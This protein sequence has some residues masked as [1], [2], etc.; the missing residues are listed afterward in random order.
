[1]KEDFEELFE[2]VKKDLKYCP[3]AKRLTTEQHLKEFLSEV[4]EVKK[5]YK[6]KDYDNLKEEL[7]DVMWDLV[8]F[9]M[10][11]EKEG[12]IKTKDIIKGILN[13]MKERKP[14]IFE[15]RTVTEEEAEK[16]WNKIKRLQKARKGEKNE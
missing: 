5:A 6:N 4:E 16:H 14:F 2:S 7:G 3:W 10:I 11:C 1:M 13:K 9:S 15:E 12:K 8:M